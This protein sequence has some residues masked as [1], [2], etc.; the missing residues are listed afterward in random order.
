MSTDK[1]GGRAFPALFGDGSWPSDGMTL[2]D[3][4]AAHCPITMEEADD[5]HMHE[6]GLISFYAAMRYEYA[7]AMI[8]ERAK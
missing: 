3:Y 7:D 2:R 5:Y 6:D 4:F 1:E 8:A